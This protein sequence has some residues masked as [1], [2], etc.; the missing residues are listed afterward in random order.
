MLQTRAVELFRLLVVCTFGD[1][2]QCVACRKLRQDFRD[3]FQQLGM[4]GPYR[5]RAVG[6]VLFLLRGACSASQ[7]L[8]AGEQGCMKGVRAVAVDFHAGGFKCVEGLAHLRR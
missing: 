8:K 4:R 6:D 7:V 5:R 1:E 2:D 3:P